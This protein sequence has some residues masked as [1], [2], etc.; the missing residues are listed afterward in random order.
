VTG[1]VHDPGSYR[2]AMEAAARS[3]TRRVPR[4]DKNSA[5]RWALARARDVVFGRAHR[6]PVRSFAR[7]WI[8]D[9]KGRAIRSNG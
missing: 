4:A 2:E 1:V 9:L 6:A 8:A 7:S 3:S 5:R